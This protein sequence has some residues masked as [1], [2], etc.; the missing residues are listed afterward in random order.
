MD[1]L[2]D[3]FA[4]LDLTDADFLATYLVGQTFSGISFFCLS[5][6]S[7]VAAGSEGFMG[8]HRPSQS[9]VG[10]FAAEYSGSAAALDQ[11]SG[12]DFESQEIILE[13]VRDSDVV[14]FSMFCSGQGQF[15]TVGGEKKNCTRTGPVSYIDF[16]FSGPL[17]GASLCV[18][19]FSD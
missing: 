6:Q 11:T 18:R 8:T 9:S 7:G 2:I 17:A 5:I 12:N 1:G 3:W 10:S 14:F 19:F 15:Y 16:L 4:W 13:R